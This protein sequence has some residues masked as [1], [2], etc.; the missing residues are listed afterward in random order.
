[1]NY[2]S[3]SKTKP[4]DRRRTLPPAM[5]QERHRIANLIDTL[6]ILSGE[7]LHSELLPLVPTLG[8]ITVNAI[9]IPRDE[10][11]TS[12]SAVGPI[13][14]IGSATEL[15]ARAGHFASETPILVPFD[16]PQ[17]TTATLV[18]LTGSDP[19]VDAFLIDCRDRRCERLDEL[20][21]SP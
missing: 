11:T 16:V 5:A 17:N 21:G 10:D 18:D 3:D 20:T 1:M 19:S 13:R 15:V 9:R 2:E 12:Q 8:T 4:G 6:G 7:P 14:N